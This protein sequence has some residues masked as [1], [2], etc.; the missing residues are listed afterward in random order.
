MTTGGD[1]TWSFTHEG[2]TSD[3][4]GTYGLDD[5]G[6]LVLSGED[7]QMVSA[8]GIDEDGKMHFMLIGAPDGDPGLDFTRD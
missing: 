3:I 6:L 2:R 1:Y 4:K 7:T 5:N 8:V